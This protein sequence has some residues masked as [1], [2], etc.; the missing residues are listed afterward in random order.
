MYGSMGGDVG[1]GDQAPRPFGDTATAEGA[2]FWP[3]IYMPD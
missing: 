1:L 2:Q 3:K